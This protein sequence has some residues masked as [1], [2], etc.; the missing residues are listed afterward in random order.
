MAQ[1]RF[2]PGH[3]R[4]SGEIAF[5]A[6]A[7]AGEYQIYWLPHNTTCMMRYC[8]GSVATEYPLLVGSN[9]AATAEEE[10]LRSLPQ[11]QYMG[12]QARRAFGN[13]SD[14]EL[15]A[16][17]SEM[18]VAGGLD[19]FLLIPADRM[20]PL[21]LT[22]STTGDF[23][24]GWLGAPALG[25]H[26]HDAQAVLGGDTV[27]QP[28]EWVALQLGVWARNESLEVTAVTMHGDSQLI[29]NFSCI[30]LG[31]NDYSGVPFT[32]QWRLPAGRLSAL[33][34]GVH[35]PVAPVMPRSLTGSL[36]VTLRQ[37]DSSSVFN[38]S[39]PVALSVSGAAILNSGDNQPEKLS[40]LRWL[41]SQ[42]G[43]SDHVPKPFTAVDT[44]DW[45]HNRTLRILGRSISIGLCGL[46][47]SVSASLGL[48]PRSI[49]QEIFSFADVGQALRWVWLPAG[50]KLTNESHSEASWF[51]HATSVPAGF[52][53]SVTG[54]LS[55]E[56]YLDY[57]I[58][59]RA[60]A[61]GQAEST[62]PGLSIAATLRAPYLAGLG[63]AGRRLGAAAWPLANVPAG[64][65]A[66][67]GCD[68]NNSVRPHLDIIAAVFALAR[69][70]LT[71]SVARSRSF[72][73]H[74]HSQP[75]Q[76][77][78]CGWAMSTAA[79]GLNGRALVHSGT[80]PGSKAAAHGRG[81]TAA[82][83]SS[84]RPVHP[85]KCMAPQQATL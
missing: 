45:A 55:F 53:L 42:I 5:A 44:S 13:F 12:M 48:A 43:V 24:I 64:G 28:G 39:V 85:R 82:S 70:V 47:Q 21:R 74:T 38:V 32:K 51:A 2:L 23:P 76:R 67:S 80:T 83:T 46:P 71:A 11:A 26:R 75:A 63:R 72:H 54:S 66:A 57:E 1:K 34:M 31:G 27:V 6:I 56:G 69:S 62:F 59:I 25:D 73:W 19:S 3:S 58:A 84:T 52:A 65:A 78:L 18:A 49:G 40:R 20:R 68:K 29:A 9:P 8:G 61:A 17:P 81:P 50:P 77:R 30:S 15:V 60:A 10:T 41:D 79:C 14:M 35:I 16:T 4:Y 36:E 33:W 7:G 22:N 37:G